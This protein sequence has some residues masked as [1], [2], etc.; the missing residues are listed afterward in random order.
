V[1]PLQSAIADR[2][3][4][5]DYPTPH[6]L[7]D[8]IVEQAITG[9]RP[10]QAITVLD[11]ACGDGRFL[12]AAAR[13]IRAGGGRPVLVGAEID[14]A[15]ADMARRAT[16]DADATIDCL[17]SLEASWDGERF[18]VVLG[19]PPYLSQMAAATSR[20]GASRHGGGPYA[21]AAVE[22]LALAVRLA[23]P[24][25]RIGVVLP[26]SVLASRDAESVRVAADEAAAITWSW[27]SPRPVFAAQVFVCA[28]VLERG[29]GRRQERRPWTE[30]VTR[31]L[32]VPALPSLSTEGELG[33]R[34]R[35]T[36]N[37][38]D[39]Y[40]GLVPAVGEDGDGPPLVTSGLVDP[41]RCHWGARPV[42]FAKRR[43]HRPAV[44]LA[45]LDA[46]MRRWADGL[47]V[48]KV[49]VA[50]QTRVIEAVADP[51][52]RWIPGIPLISGRPTGSVDAGTIAAVLTSPVASAWAWR[53]AAGTGL[54]AATMRLGPRW[55]AELPWPAGDLAMATAALDAGDVAACGE[56]VT[57]AYG[58]EPAIARAW[59]LRWLPNGVL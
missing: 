29:A 12:V 11:P 59:W 33:D 43:F 24:G 2:K 34:A 3:R 40:Y 8:A 48:P 50:N 39:Q 13:R 49:V 37:F 10:G 44:D 58:L 5:G 25:G 16:S 41:G 15:A 54:S 55:L 31:R 23:R 35:L 30:I 47:L 21:D 56:A 38:R 1:P 18:D 51:G 17:D 27:W 53:R 6:W 57:A 26:Q 20:G 42:T 28:L 19:N 45:R 36:A 9:V 4:R 7:V 52:G 46:P 22:F 14:S 32:G